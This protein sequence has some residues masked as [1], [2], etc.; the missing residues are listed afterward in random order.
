MFTITWTENSRYQLKN[1]KTWTMSNGLW[2]I[3]SYDKS[4]IIQHIYDQLSFLVYGKFWDLS[5]RRYAVWEV[6]V[7]EIASWGRLQLG[8]FQLGE[9]PAGGSVSWGSA[10]WGKCQ[11][12]KMLAGG[13]ASR[14]MCQLGEVTVGRS[15]SWGNFLLGDLSLSD[16]LGTFISISIYL[17][18]ATMLTEK[19]YVL[20]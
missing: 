11:L 2:S 4:Y 15:V 13:S 10:S 8:K 7:G 1:Y 20:G 3:F 12:G 9:V 19:S 18:I 5:R 14:G 6:Q 17:I 16:F